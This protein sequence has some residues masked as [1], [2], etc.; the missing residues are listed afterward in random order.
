M[1]AGVGRVK[2][3]MAQE[4][5]FDTSHVMIDFTQ[6]KSFGQDPLILEEGKGIRVTDVFGKSYIDGL[7]GVFTVN[8]GHGI[9]EIIEVATEQAKKITFTAPTMATNPAALKLAELLI[10]ITPPQYSTFKFFSGGSEATEAAIKM[11]RQYQLQTGHGSKFKVISRYMGYHGGTGF[12]MAASGQI[13]WKW[14]FE[15]LAP[16]FIHVQ[17]PA[18][19]GCVACARLDHCNHACIDLV[20]D[21]ILREGPETVAAI[22]AEPIMMSAGVHVPPAEYVPRLRELCDKHHIVLIFDE[23]ITGFGRTGTLFAAEQFGVW[24]DITAFGK[25]VSG[26]YAPLSGIMIADKIASEFWGEPEAGVQF[27]AGHTY[28]GNP[29]AC[30]VSEAVVRYLLDRDVIANAATVGDYLNQRL[31]D[32]SHKHSVINDVRGMGLL[33]GIGLSEPIGRD[34]F[35]AARQRGLLVRASPPFVCLAPPLV[36]TQEEIDEIVELLDAAISDVTG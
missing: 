27:H 21:A 17:P 3:I 10:Q 6:M 1:P 34:I 5:T 28:G 24:P 30:A 33:R 22:I 11:A 4:T 26:G 18:R 13:D 23:I 19:P 32:L 2:A 9:E 14:R 16:G 29:V 25:G 7:S 35:T 36:T 31:I 20:E 15:P 8:I 12:A